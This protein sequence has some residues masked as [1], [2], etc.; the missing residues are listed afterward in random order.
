MLRSATSVL[1]DEFEKKVVLDKEEE[2]ESPI[3]GPTGD[4][5]LNTHSVDP[6]VF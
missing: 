1:I 4:V 6:R 5:V 2:T 3:Q